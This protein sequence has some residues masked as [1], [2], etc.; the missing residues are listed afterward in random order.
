[1]LNNTN[2]NSIANDYNSTQT[3]LTNTNNIDNSGNNLAANA[4]TNTSP[5]MSSHSNGSAQLANMSSGG[6]NNNTNNKISPTGSTS[7]GHWGHGSG[8]SPIG[9]MSCMNNM[10]AGA[11][12]SVGNGGGGFQHSNAVGHMSSMAQ[13]VG[14]P[15]GF[16]TANDLTKSSLYYASQF[17]SLGSRGLAL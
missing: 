14:D 3:G 1:M 16:V 8:G 11:N 10:L 13:N 6:G 5:W 4:N 2:I 7:S 9:A 15:F 12:D 17:G